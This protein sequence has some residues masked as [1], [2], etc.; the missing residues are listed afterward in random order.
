MGRLEAELRNAFC[1]LD[2]GEYA[3]VVAGGESVDWLIGKC[4]AL[5]GRMPRCLPTAG[6][7]S[8]KPSR[9]VFSL[10]SGAILLIH[11]TK[12]PGRPGEGSMLTVQ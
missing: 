9:S 7:R 6:R 4:R 8:G 5:A 11:A 12:F 1:L 2:G 3:A 10:A